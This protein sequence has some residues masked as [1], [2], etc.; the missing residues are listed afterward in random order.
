MGGSHLVD[1]PTMRRRCWC[2]M[3]MDIAVRASKQGYA[4]V[5]SAERRCTVRE[6]GACQQNQGPGAT[7]SEPNEKQIRQHKHGDTAHDTARSYSAKYFD[8]LESAEWVDG[9]STLEVPR[10]TRSSSVRTGSTRCEETATL[11][12]S[13]HHH[14]L[15]SACD[16]HCDLLGKRC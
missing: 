10:L 4:D 5:R 2:T 7:R 8:A 16:R 12:S 6:R 9:C 3:L 14:P 13:L 11:T 1:S 15:A